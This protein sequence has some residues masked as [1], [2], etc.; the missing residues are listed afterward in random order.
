MG[1]PKLTTAAPL[2]LLIG[3]GVS[4]I[5]TPASASFVG[6]LEPAGT[7]ELQLFLNG[8][9]DTTSLLGHVGSQ[10][11]SLTVG[12]TTNT[13][14]DAANGF[15]NIK[16]DSGTL[17]SITFTPTNSSLFSDFFFRG[18]LNGQG[19]ALG[20]VSVSVTDS[21]GTT[22]SGSGFNFSN[23]ANQDFAS[24]GVLS[25]DGE[26]IKQVTISSNVG[27]KEVKQIV[28][29]QTSAVPETSTW[30]MMMLGFFGVGFL[31]YR[32]KQNRQA[33]RIG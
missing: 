22:F 23:Q 16:P 11:S 10:N 6:G 15:A 2:A 5:T 9:N 4:G 32:R 12:I 30:A 21:L 29:S 14:V 33:F 19:N 17:T 27:F 28:F 13:L 7:T 1:I 20:N 26:T 8:E 31:A 25:L 3:L 24:F 18:Q